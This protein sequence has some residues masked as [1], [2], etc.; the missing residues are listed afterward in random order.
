M[1]RDRD[2]Q[3]AGE[4]ACSSADRPDDGRECG[5]QPCVGYTWSVSQT[6]HPMGLELGVRMTCPTEHI[7]R[8]QGYQRCP[9]CFCTK[10]A[11]VNVGLSS[12]TGW[13]VGRLWSCMWGRHQ[14]PDS[15]VRESARKPCR[16]I[17]V[18]R[19]D[20]SRPA[21]VQLAALQLLLP[22]H[23]C[24]PGCSQGLEILDPKSR[25][26]D[27]DRFRLLDP[28]KRELSGS[29]RAARSC[30]A[31]GR[32]QERG[33]CLPAWLQRRLLRDPATVPWDPGRG[34]QLLQQRSGGRQRDVLRRCGCHSSTLVC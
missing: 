24:R 15:T 7:F 25:C 5:T 30:W 34:R 19:E 1:C 10:I 8:K 17:S 13:Q 29:F 21:A 9:V 4:Y 16:R 3:N 6:P 2:G 32:L 26:I 33:L 27:T 23:M 18:P 28:D 11:Y 31:A 20:P 12:L 22:N 14:E